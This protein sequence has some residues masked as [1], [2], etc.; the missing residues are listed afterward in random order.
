[1]KRAADGMA[2]AGGSIA[3]YEQVV[4]FI[5]SY[6]FQVVE[7]CGRCVKSESDLRCEV[8]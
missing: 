8:K 2:L 6:G 1:M 5:I 4:G 7:A 3:N